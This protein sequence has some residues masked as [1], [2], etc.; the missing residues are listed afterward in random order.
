MKTMRIYTLVALLLM[1]GSGMLMAQDVYEMEEFL[2]SDDLVVL[3]NHSSDNE[4]TALTSSIQG[5]ALK[6]YNDDGLLLDSILLWPRNEAILDFE[7]FTYKEGQTL[8]Y[9]LEKQ[10][11]GDTATFNKVTIGDDMIPVLNNMIGMGLIV[12]RLL[13][14]QR[15]SMCLSIKTEGAFS[16]TVRYKTASAL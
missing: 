10:L 15:K 4:I 2:V 3:M 6:K 7:M 11:D 8:V 13:L 1:A 9:Y 12:L 5:I 16:P 14:I